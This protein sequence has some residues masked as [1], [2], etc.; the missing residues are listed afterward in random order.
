MGSTVLVLGGYG[1]TGATLS[2]LLLEYSDADVIVAGR[3]LP[4]AEALA[5]ELGARYPERV[6]ARRADAADPASLDAAFTGIDMVAVA[7]STLA[8]AE[9]VIDAA[10]RADIDYFDLQMSAAAKLDALERRRPEVESRGRRFITDGGIHPGLSAAMIRAVAPAFTRLERAEVAGLM[11]VDWNAYGFA[12]DTIHE[13]AAELADYRVEALVDGL[14]SK[15]SWGEAVR[16]FDFGPPWGRQRCSLMFMEE[17]R[18]LSQ[19]IPSLR[20][21]GF[22]VSGFNQVTDT[23][24]MPLGLAVMKLSPDLLGRPYSRAL[25]WSLR[26]FARPPYITVWQLEAE[27][28]LAGGQTPRGEL[29]GG[30]AAQEQ[31]TGGRAVAGLRIIHPDGYWLTA[32]TAAACLLQYVDGSLRTPGVH[33]QALA[34][35]PARLLCDLRRMGARLQGYG[36]DEQAVL[37]SAADP[38]PAEATPEAEA[39]PGRKRARS[40]PKKDEAED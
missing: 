27:G 31:S 12:Q 3:T 28:E 20:A 8:H 34:V 32:A 35:Q 37:S 9:T 5:A 11:K 13:F 24:M 23:V 36:V 33:L 40:K 16:S 19:T 25:T 21:C 2:E 15:V 30:Q 1:V 17:L 4:K 26:A 18:R 10:L 39:K 6:A 22:Y 14:W 29:A 38:P 7:S